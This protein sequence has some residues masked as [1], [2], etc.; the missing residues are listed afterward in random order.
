MLIPIYKLFSN[1]LIQK[2]L[3][4]TKSTEVKESSKMRTV[5]Y[6]HFHQYIDYPQSVSW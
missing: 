6:F 1:P 3:V 2:Y 5:T 4:R